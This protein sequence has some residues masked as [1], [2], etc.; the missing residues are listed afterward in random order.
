MDLKGSTGPDWEAQ[1]QLETQPGT[2]WSCPISALPESASPGPKPSRYFSGGNE[3][4][5]ARL[6]QRSA[7][8]RRDWTIKG[9]VESKTSP[10]DGES[11]HE[12]NAHSS[13]KDVDWSSPSRRQTSGSDI[14]STT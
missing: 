4:P 2:A 6:V 9:R 12:E 13:P 1:R 10:C 14:N 5:A 3:G 8:L 7:S 11:Q